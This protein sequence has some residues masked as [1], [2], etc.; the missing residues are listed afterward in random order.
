MGAMTDESEWFYRDKDRTVGPITETELISAYFL[1][2][3]TGD[4]PVWRR[5][6]PQ[7]SS[8][9]EAIDLSAR[10]P[11]DVPAKLN[12][13]IE[14]PPAQPSSFPQ[15]VGDTLLVA[16]HG[17]NPVEKWTAEPVYPWRR[18]VA[19]YLDIMLLGGIAAFGLGT[20]TYASSPS[21]HR[22]IWESSD[23]LSFVLQNALVIALSAIPCAILVGITGGTPGKWLMGVKVENVA[24]R[25]IGLA[26]SIKRELL[27]F[28]QG[29]GF[30]IP[31]VVFFTGLAARGALLADK[32]TSWDRSVGAVVLY[33]KL[34]AGTVTLQ[35][36]GVVLLLALI[37]ATRALTSEG[38]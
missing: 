22:V 12:T 38:Y 14:L 9:R 7:W 37:A 35:I 1:Q 5:G 24:G 11:P 29:L 27:V 34:D 2:R 13:A 28:V 15:Q 21:L 19:R 4:T 18:Y 25:T 26:H 31:I 36:V 30:G 23:P 10:A 32:S 17:E 8:L 16:D 3:V 20:A 33:R 6:A